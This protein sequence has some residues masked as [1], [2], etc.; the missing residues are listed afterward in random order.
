[1]TTNIKQRQVPEGCGVR[2]RGAAQLRPREPHL[3]VLRER[4]NAPKRGRR[5]TM[6]APAKCICAVAA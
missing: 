6:S 3:P 2:L 1:M 5:S 4:G